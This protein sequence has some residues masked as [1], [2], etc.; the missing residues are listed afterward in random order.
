MLW[1][2]SE[3]ARQRTYDCSVCRRKELDLERNCYFYG[4]EEQEVEFFQDIQ[5]EDLG[6][7]FK[8]GQKIRATTETICSELLP[9]LLDIFKNESPFEVL[10]RILK[11]VCPKSLIT[12]EIDHFIT[13]EMF[14]KEYHIPPYAG[15]GLEDYSQRMVSVFSAIVATRERVK[16]K[17]IREIRNSNTGGMRNK[18]SGNI[19]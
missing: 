17:E 14:A 4:E 11:R 12:E 7:V 9:E 5:D 8:K 2:G 1:V 19:S 10:Q 6:L 13:L 16:A 15:I 3:T 18:P